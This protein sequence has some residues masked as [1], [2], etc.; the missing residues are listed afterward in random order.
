MS[1]ATESTATMP[2]PKRALLIAGPTASGK[3]ALALELARERNGVV[4]NA[5]SMQVYRELRILTARPTPEE[6]ALSPH[7]LYGQI[8]GFEPWSVALWLEA[9]RREIEAAWAAGMLPVVVGGTGLYFKALER[10]LADIP[11]IPDAIR[12]KWR[13]AEGDLH[14]ALRACD[15][16]SASRLKPNDRQRI[17]RALEVVEGT[18]EPMSFWRSGRNGTAILA[19]A[20]IERRLVIPERGGLYRRAEMRFEKMIASGALEEVRDLVALGIPPTQP[21]MKA[22]GIPQLAA[23]LKGE[24]ALDEAVR[25]A[26]TA[27]RRYVKRQLTW[28]RHQG[29]A[30][31]NTD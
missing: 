24:I 20:E 2:L 30:W 16:E 28:W 23:H 10:G 12:A 22:I 6:E 9:A 14:S 17:I 18:G 1:T 7:R 4:I 27:T 15:P 11:P 25:L 19:D 26:K 13:R 31:A 3:S 29:I 8:S 5:D 21:I